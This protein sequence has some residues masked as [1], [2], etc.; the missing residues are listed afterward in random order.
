[1]SVTRAGSGNYLAATSPAYIITISD[2]EAEAAAAI[3]KANLST[4]LYTITGSTNKIEI[5]LADKYWYDIVFVDVKK[6]VLVNGKYVLRYV[7]IDTAVLDES[8]AA[9]VYTKI[10]IKTG[11]VIRV[12][13]VGAVTDTPVKYVTVK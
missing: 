13:V 3:A 10:G 9:T 4:I 2:S 5:D 6:R 1:V 7:R 11:D 12:S 8:A